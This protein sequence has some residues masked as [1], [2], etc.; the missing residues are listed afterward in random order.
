MNRLQ[1]LDL[2]SGI[3]GFS[4]GLERTGGFETVAFC[5][6][7][8]YACRVLKKHWPNVPIFN[9]VKTITEE[10]NGKPDL[11]CGGYPCQGE[12]VAGLRGGAEDDRW[13]WPEMFNCVKTYRPSW[14]I[15]ENVA[16]H[17]SMGLDTVLADLEGAGYAAQAFIIPACAL[18][19][20]HRRDRCW[21]VANAKHGGIP[22]GWGVG[23]AGQKNPDQRGICGNEQQG[24]QEQA[25]EVLANA[26][27]PR[28]EEQH[29]T[30]QPGWAGYRARRAVERWAPWPTESAMGR[31]AD[32][33]P[34]R[35]DRIRCLGNAVVP[36]IPEMI[37]YA[38]LEAMNDNL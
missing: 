22:R 21:V 37:G 28:C 15:G 25:G 14:V 38:I 10:F 8:P 34:R 1:V 27:R 19:A 13:L 16:G 23:N 17:V 3:G 2:F 31:V 6:I 26:G 29:I 32:G 30:A 33:V 5:E 4:L 20:P 9:N 35:V 24:L 11:I 18:D 36:D 7:N 12:S